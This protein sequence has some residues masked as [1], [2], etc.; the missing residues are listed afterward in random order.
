METTNTT[1]QDI[2]EYVEYLRL[3]RGVERASIS[4]DENNVNITVNDRAFVTKSFYDKL[5]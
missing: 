2:K 1:M 4:F 5:P 3:E